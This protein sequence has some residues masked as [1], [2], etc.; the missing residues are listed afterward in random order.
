LESLSL[1]VGVNLQ[2]H[3]PLRLNV[4]FLLNK[5]V[6]FS[7][8]LDLEMA[9][10]EVG[11]ELAVSDLNGKLRF[12]RT[13]Q[14]LYGSGP[15]QA[16]HTMECARCLD[17]YQHTLQVHLDE[18]FVYPAEKAEDPLLAIPESGVLDLHPLLREML[19]LE[20]PLQPLCREGCRG[21]CPIC[22]NNLNNEQCSHPDQDID[23]RLAPL[24]RLLSES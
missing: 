24:K 17:A 4:G 10:V 23:P 2:S 8:I 11:G 7:R 13:G 12:T 14:G 16:D 3:D 6:G 1:G 18:L 5:S 19:I 9:S 20:V 22:G 21:L 15:I